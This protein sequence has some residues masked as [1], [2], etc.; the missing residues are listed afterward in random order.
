MDEHRHLV[1][2]KIDHL[3]FDAF[4]KVFLLL[5]FEDVLKENWG[6][7]RG[8]LYGAKFRSSNKS[9]CPFALIKSSPTII[10]SVYPNLRQ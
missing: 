5:Q 4:S 10:L 2:V 6:M 3:P 7:K 1:V 8:G 9:A